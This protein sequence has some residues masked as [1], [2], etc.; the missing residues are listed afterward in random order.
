LID[1][2]KIL[3][4]GIDTNRLLN[5]LEFKTLVSEKT[6][7]LSSKKITKYHF[8]KI[9]IYDSGIVLFSGSIHKLY[10][11]LKNIKAPN[12]KT[13]ELYKGYNGNQFTI[14]NIIEVREHLQNLFNCKPI[15]M[16]FQN[17][18]FGINTIPNFHPQ[19]FLRG[20]LYHNG[21]QFEYKYNGNLAQSMHQQFI[22]KIYNKSNQYRMS[23]ETLRIELKYL[24][25]K[26]VNNI[27]IKT[28]TD[29]NTLTLNEVNKLL[30]KRFDEVV[31]YDYTIR[32]EELRKRLKQTLNNYSNPRYWF[33]NVTVKKRHEHKNRLKQFI[34][35]YSDN[36][37][38]QLRQ[39]IA[40]KGGIINRLS[41]TL[42]G[43]IINHSSIGVKIPFSHLR[44]TAN[45][46]DRI[47]PI[48]GLP[49][50]HE[51]EGS[52]YI[53]TSSL[54]YLHNQDRKKFEEV[55]SLLLNK[56]NGNHPKFENGIISHLAKQVRNR[57]YNPIKIK[58][59]GYNQKRYINQFELF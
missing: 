6:G 37:H 32:K 45:K 2:T 23:T 50:A 15:Q 58:R 48:T 29:I 33:E 55:C 39:E 47:C 42:K 24:K 3:L 51:K 27:G 28:F 36:L 54:N 5:K 7:E 46:K 12:Y 21:K 59:Y 19:L 4:I 14:D 34:I 44:K 31:Y 40:L 56:T 57:Y 8:C 52:K 11:S 25:M 53:K 17:I 41:E 43:G 20:L 18:E 38:Q 26:E 9:T 13:K 35:K 49:L 16:Q 10:N 22:F 30:L 1:Y